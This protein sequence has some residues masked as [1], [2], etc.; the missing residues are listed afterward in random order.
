MSYGETKTRNKRKYIL[1]FRSW[2]K[3]DL[4]LALINIELFIVKIEAGKASR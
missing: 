1:N 4:S 3:W 2:I